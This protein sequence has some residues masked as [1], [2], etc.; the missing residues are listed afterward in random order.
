M[1]K[2]LWSTTF[3][4]SQ[5]R[6]AEAEKQVTCRFLFEVLVFAVRRKVQKQRNRSYTVFVVVVVFL[7]TGFRRPQKRSTETEIGQVSSSV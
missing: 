4:R 6:T 1:A 2:M 7:S 5:R 3:R